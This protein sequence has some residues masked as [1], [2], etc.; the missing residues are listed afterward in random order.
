MS[1]ASICFILFIS[2]K[3]LFFNLRVT[4]R[5]YL[6]R[7][8]IIEFHIQCLFFLIYEHLGWMVV[9][10]MKLKTYI[11]LCLDAALLGE[12]I[13][14]IKIGKKTGFTMYLLLYFDKAN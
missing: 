3:C 12:N 2:I 7:S 1:T 13:D 5:N 8:L 14:N 9:K 6:S 10:I 11:N 4:W